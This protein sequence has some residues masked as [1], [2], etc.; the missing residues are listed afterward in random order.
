MPPL[1][2]HQ[3]LMH[4]QPL[5]T[6]NLLPTPH[7]HQSTMSQHLMLHLPQPTMSLH[8]MPP[9]LQPTMNQHLQLITPL[10][11]HLHPT[12]PLLPTMS[13]SPTT[14]RSTT[15]TAQLVMPVWT[16]PAMLTHPTLSSAA[17]ASPSPPAC[18]LT[19]SLDV[20]L[21]EFATTEGTDLKEPALSAPTAHSSISTCSGASSGT[22]LTA[23]R[24]SPSTASTLT[25]C[26]IPTCPNPSW[27]STETLSH[28]L[29][30]VMRTPT[31]Q[32]STMLHPTMLLLT[33]LLPS[34]ML[35][36]TMLLP[37][38]TPPPSILWQSPTTP[39]P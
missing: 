6:M 12:T 9:L 29:L 22:Q 28:P 10:W 18:T 30:W 1:N 5:P 21:I 33:M 14:S 15:S 27:T 32:L 7:P 26:S 20:R 4:P 19:L 39:H 11:W 2:H 23:A 16:T 3:P 24:P 36:L 25:P 13:P 8:H 35:L 17:P 31:T 38:T 34:T 37:S